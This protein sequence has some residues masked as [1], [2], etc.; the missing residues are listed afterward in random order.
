MA[1]V[2]TRKVIAQSIERWRASATQRRLYGGSTMT[3]FLVGYSDEP[4]DKWLECVAGGATPAERKA[5]AI[6]QFL[7]F[8][9]TREQKPSE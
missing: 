7:E 5:A 4:V 2:K 1:K 6:N 8:Q 9:S 3:K